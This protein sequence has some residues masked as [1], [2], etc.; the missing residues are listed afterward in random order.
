MKKSYI[1]FG[2]ITI[3]LCALYGRAQ[4]CRF[5][6]YT[7]DN[8]TMVID[9][10]MDTVDYYV[11]DSLHQLC[12][13]V[14]SYSAVGMVPSDDESR[15]IA[16]TGGT[17]NPS[18]VNTP[19]AVLCRLLQAYGQHNILAVKQL[20][21]PSDAAVF[22]N[23]FTNDTLVERYMNFMNRIQK[24][25][26]LFSY[27][28]HEYTVFMVGY[29]HQDV[30]VKTM[31][32]H[33][34]NIGGQW[35]AC[36]ARDS[37]AMTANLVPFLYKK[38][39]NDFLGND[40]DGDGIPN[41]VDN[42]PCVSNDQTDTDG[43]GVGDVCDNCPGTPNAN[44]RDF[45]GDGIGD[46]CDNCRSIYNPEQ[47]DTDHDG[48]GDTCDNC[49]YYPNPRQYDFDGDGIGDDC[50]DDIDGDDIPNEQDNDMD[51]DGV[52]DAEDIC[53]L[54]FNPSQ[55]DSDG[56]GIGDACDNCPLKANPGQEDLD[57][58][59]VGDA[60]DSDSD[61][62]G[63]LDNLDNCPQVPNHDQQDVDCDGIGD[64][65]DPDRD[66]D[67]VPNERDNCPDMFNPD[68]QDANQNGIGD[69]CE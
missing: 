63:I 17:E 24:M 61:G 56:D 34:Q 6:A 65:C 52:P 12:E 7:T 54:H 22:D 14:F 30:M 58:D 28:M 3:L 53:P 20:Y 8:Y 49:K 23:F 35:Y 46:V 57:A 33:L 55:I 15:I 48:V 40:I 42:C 1:T 2:L 69:V 10:N 45:D 11:P 31:P 66:G 19:P 18:S 67:G 4:N 25:K 44:Q 68:Q 43:D 32:F 26:L 62:D 39:V 64:V 60:C 9:M 27:E 37:S 51:N 59:G 38:T 13:K 5:P 50:D 29:Y 36:V 16:L 41:D 21:R 47:T